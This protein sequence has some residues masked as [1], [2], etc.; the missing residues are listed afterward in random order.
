MIASVEF[1]GLPAGV[2]WAL[3]EGLR[4]RGLEVRADSVLDTD[5]INAA[6]RVMERM[7]RGRGWYNVAVEPRTEQVSETSVKLTFVVRALPPERRLAPKRSD[8]IA[9]RD[10]IA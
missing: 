6:A 9:R 2:E 4:R 5:K 7:L 1:E 8:R 3:R 10:A